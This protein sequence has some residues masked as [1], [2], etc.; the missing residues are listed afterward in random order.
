MLGTSGYIHRLDY[1]IDFVSRG[2]TNDPLG[3][4]RAAGGEHARFLREDGNGKNVVDEHAQGVSGR[5]VFR[6]HERRQKLPVGK[7]GIHLSAASGTAFRRVVQGRPQPLAD[8]RRRWVVEGM[9]KR[10]NR[11]IRQPW[12]AKEQGIR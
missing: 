9:A 8:A 10:T 7:A 11:K 1:S 12:S 4:D 6:P 3:A 5:D 2:H